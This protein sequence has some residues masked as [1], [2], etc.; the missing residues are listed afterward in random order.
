MQFDYIRTG[1]TQNCLLATGT[2]N[3]PMILNFTTHQYDNYPTVVSSSARVFRANNSVNATACYQHK[4][5]Q[6]HTNTFTDIV[7]VWLRKHIVNGHGYFTNKNGPRKPRSLC[8]CSFWPISSS[9][10]SSR[11]KWNVYAKNTFHP[12]PILFYIFV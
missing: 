5:I 10:S 6:R 7:R 3:D 11:C 4:K 9:F 12:I 8:V 2:G 1:H